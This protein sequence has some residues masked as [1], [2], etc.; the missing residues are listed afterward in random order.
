LALLMPLAL[1]TAFERALVAAAALRAVVAAIAFATM[2]KFR[3]T[4]A[5]H[6][7]MH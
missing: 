2:S 1:L 3:A 5:A 4:G 7:H 6:L